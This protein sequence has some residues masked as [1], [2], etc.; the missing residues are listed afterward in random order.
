[1]KTE[2]AAVKKPRILQDITGAEQADI[3]ELGQKGTANEDGGNNPQ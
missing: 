2:H 1:M 3:A